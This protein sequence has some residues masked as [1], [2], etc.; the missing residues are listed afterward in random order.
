[1]KLLGNVVCFSN[2]FVKCVCMGVCKFLC[3]EDIFI[4]FIIKKKLIVILV[5]SRSWRFMSDKMSDTSVK[6][7]LLLCVSMFMYCL[8][9][10]MVMR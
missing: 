4:I 6:E 7:F 5:I 2:I 10:V 9:N 8:F 3:F 1:M